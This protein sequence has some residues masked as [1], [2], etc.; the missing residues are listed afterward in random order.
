MFDKSVQIIGN[1]HV[2]KERVMAC[3]PGKAPGKRITTV[4][5]MGMFPDEETAAKWFE[6]IL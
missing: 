3:T 6:L 2:S 5:L 1:S 4:E